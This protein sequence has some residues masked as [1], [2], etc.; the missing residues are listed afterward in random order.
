MCLCPLAIVLSSLQNAADAVC[1]AFIYGSFDLQ[2]SQICLLA[3]GDS[4]AFDGLLYGFVV[5]PFGLMLL[6]S[7]LWFPDG[8]RF[9]FSYCSLTKCGKASSPKWGANSNPSCENAASS[10]GVSSRLL[11]MNLTMAP[12]HDLAHTACILRLPSLCLT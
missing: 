1:A 7:V 2:R 4:V 9:P 11:R 5:V 6:V 12:R 8:G 10:R 3:R